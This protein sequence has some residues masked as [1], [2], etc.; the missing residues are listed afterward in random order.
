MA[1]GKN[2]LERLPDLNIE[3]REAIAGAVGVGPSGLLT[4]YRYY[5]DAARDPAYIGLLD[6]EVVI[7][8]LRDLP[9]WPQAREALRKLE[10]ASRV[11]ARPRGR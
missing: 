11:I 5:R 2:L 8:K 10:P 9:F 3:D 7:D 6:Y 4:K 1:E